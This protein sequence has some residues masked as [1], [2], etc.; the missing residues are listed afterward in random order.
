MKKPR[1]QGHQNRKVWWTC[2]SSSV[3][4]GSGQGRS[5]GQGNHVARRNRNS[6]GWGGSLL[7]LGASF[8]GF[9]Y[10]DKKD[11]YRSWHEDFQASLLK[12]YLKKYPNSIPTIK[13][14]FKIK[15]VF[16][17]R[18]H[19]EM[20][21]LRKRESRKYRERGVDPEP[22]S[23]HQWKRWVVK[24][25]YERIVIAN[26]E[27]VE[28][29]HKGQL[30]VSQPPAD[31]LCRTLLNSPEVY[32]DTINTFTGDWTKRADHWCLKQDEKLGQ[33]RKWE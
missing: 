21:H 11:N 5:V 23:W 25:K 9:T 18:V 17:K 8:Y 15:K 7:H 20:L 4:G 29:L 6:T 19:K 27:F 31:E 13:E 24:D 33:D 1:I 22:R 12:T 10:W 28:Y 3:I 30:F 26:C 32:I 16:H 14:L 2:R